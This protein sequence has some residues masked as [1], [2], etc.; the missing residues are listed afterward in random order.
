MAKEKTD[1]SK[2]DVHYA[3][4]DKEQRVRKAVA[5]LRPA[6]STEMKL[7]GQMK[8]KF[9]GEELVLEVYKGLGGAYSLLEKAPE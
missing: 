7:L 4:A 3:N 6:D 1:L 2:E 8:S 9:D 5:G